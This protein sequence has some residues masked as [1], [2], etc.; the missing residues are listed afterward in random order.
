MAADQRK[1]RLMNGSSI[2]GC[3]SLGQTKMKKRKLASVQNG[4]DSNSHISLAWDRNSKKVVAK[5]EQ[6]GISRRNLRPFSYSVL[7]SGNHLADVFSIPRELFELEDL[8]EVLSNEVASLLLSS[9]FC[10]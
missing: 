7:N 9:S 6:I 2:A 1:K 4:L 10:C 3:S 5:K 8:N